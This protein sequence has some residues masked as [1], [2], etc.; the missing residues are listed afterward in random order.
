MLTFQP[1]L[2]LLAELIAMD[3][4]LLVGRSKGGAASDSGAVE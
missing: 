2:D 1:V 4:D 3:P